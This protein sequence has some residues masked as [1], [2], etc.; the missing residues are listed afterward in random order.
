MVLALAAIK[1]YNGVNY[2]RTTACGDSFV[3]VCPTIAMLDLSHRCSRF[4][5]L[6]LYAHRDCGNKRQL[7]GKNTT[8]SFDEVFLRTRCDCNSFYNF[9]IY[10]V[11]VNINTSTF[12]LTNERSFPSYHRF[13]FILR[14]LLFIN[15][16]IFTIAFNFNVK[17][18]NIFYY[19]LI[20]ILS[21]L[22]LQ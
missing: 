20:L 18:L 15:F 2:C 9:F 12:I 1:C 17:N 5:S 11:L 22:L 8:Q 19:Y 6:Q 10:I 13:F 21:K 16:L 3:R 7:N 4:P 14:F